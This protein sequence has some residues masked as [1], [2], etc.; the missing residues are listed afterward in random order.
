MFNPLKSYS[1]PALKDSCRSMGHLWP[2]GNTCCKSNDYSANYKILFKLFV[3]LFPISAGWIY[4]D[5][6]MLYIAEGATGQGHHL[7]TT[8]LRQPMRACAYIVG[9]RKKE[10]TLPTLP[11]PKGMRSQRHTHTFRCG[12]CGKCGIKSTIS[13]ICAYARANNSISCS[14]HRTGGTDR[15]SVLVRVEPSPTQNMRDNC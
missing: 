9:K 12:K 2:L 7:L 1:H 5:R 14:I 15:V 6:V 8:A 10:P 3:I 13:D 4:Y 11:T